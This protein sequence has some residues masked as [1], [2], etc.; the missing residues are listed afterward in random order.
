MKTVIHALGLFIVLIILWQSHNAKD[1][2][3]DQYLLS[4]LIYLAIVVKDLE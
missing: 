3:L 2:H 1:P 4:G